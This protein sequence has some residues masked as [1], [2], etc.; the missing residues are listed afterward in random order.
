MGAIDGERERIVHVV[1]GC[2]QCASVSCRP[3]VLW[4]SNLDLIFPP[5]NSR[6]GSYLDL[7]PEL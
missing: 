7:L 3:G 5:L 4:G 2:N 6:S 1:A